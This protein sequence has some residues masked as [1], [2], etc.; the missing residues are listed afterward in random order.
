MKYRDPAVA[1]SFYSKSKEAL[2]SELTDLMPIAQNG[3]LDIKAL[4]VP[5]AGYFYSGAVAAHAFSYI[6]ELAVKPK[7]VILLGPN[8]RVG[9]SGC[10]IPSYEDFITPLGKVP[11]DRRLCNKLVEKGLVTENDDV[12]TW[13]HSLEVQ[14]P[15]LQHCL[16]VFD[17]LPILVGQ[18]EVENLA[19]ILSFLLEQ[20]DFLIIVSSDLSHFNPQ[21]TAVQMDEATIE[22]IINM[23]C[24]LQPSQACGCHALNGFLS[25]SQ[26]K[27][28]NIKLVNKANSGKLN[29]IKN[30]VVGYASFVLF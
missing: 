13:E 22:K 27:E 9:L 28:W 6:S 26:T 4:I 1:G 8:H 7:K 12:H 23:D 16:D 5:H 29:N 15:F 19:G 2:Q 10:A 24:D 3:G 11:V 14:L 30:E 25:F 18:T 21:N 20:D 17:I